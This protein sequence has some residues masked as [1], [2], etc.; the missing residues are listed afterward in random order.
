MPSFR[1]ILSPHPHALSLQLRWRKQAGNKP[2]VGSGSW[3][4]PGTLL[5]LHS[6]APFL[7]PPSSLRSR[8]HPCSHDG[9]HKCP[10]V[11]SFQ[12]PEGPLLVEERWP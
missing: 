6:P 5:V 11:T 12:L 1:P 9:E 10:L 3:D 7:L 4:Q 8:E 2:Q